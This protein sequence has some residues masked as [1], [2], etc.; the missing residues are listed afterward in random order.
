MCLMLSAVPLVY[1]MTICPMVF[2]AGLLLVVVLGWL[3]LFEVPLLSPLVLLLL[4][5]FM[6]PVSSQL[7]LRTLFCTL[8]MAQYGYL[9]LPSTPLRCFS[10]SL[11]SSGVVQT[12]LALWVSVPMTLYLEDKL[13]WLSHNKYWS[14]CVGFWYTWKDRELSARGVTGCQGMVFPHSLGSLPL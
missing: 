5:L 9:Q 12:T 6:F 3:L 2:F 10:S 4:M 7:F 13:W 11:R 14:V 1:G 8:L